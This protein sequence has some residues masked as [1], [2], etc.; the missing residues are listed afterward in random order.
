MCL[1]AGR[2]ANTLRVPLS[3]ETTSACCQDSLLCALSCRIPGKATSVMWT[4][5]V[6][7]TFC[8]GWKSPGCAHHHRGFGERSLCAP[9]ALGPERAAAE[10]PERTCGPWCWASGSAR[11]GRAFGRGLR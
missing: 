7:Q 4:L 10:V 11:Q 1:Q 5:P 6:S 9:M 3:R 2:L 8:A